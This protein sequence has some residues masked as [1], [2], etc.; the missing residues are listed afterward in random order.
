MIGEFG[1]P[2]SY[3]DRQRARGCARPSRSCRP[4]RQI[5]ALLYYDANPAGQGPQG[6][7]A[8]NGDAAA[9]A[10]FRAIARQPYFNPAGGR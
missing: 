1:V 8:L 10:V 3:G 5:K 4:T 7:Y 6:S 2:V 9:L